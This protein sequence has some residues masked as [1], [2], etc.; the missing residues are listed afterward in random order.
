MNIIPM[1]DYFWIATANTLLFENVR[2]MAHC[3]EVQH[4]HPIQCCS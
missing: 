4:S 2:C 3:S 1:P